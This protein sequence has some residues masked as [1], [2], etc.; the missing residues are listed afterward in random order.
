M[1]LVTLRVMS[2]SGRITQP[3]HVMTIVR[4]VA[5]AEAVSAVGRVRM[6]SDRKADMEV[7]LTC[8][9]PDLLC[10]KGC[11]LPCFSG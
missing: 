10:E 8:W 1:G 4:N 3:G 7:L 11:A 2:R 6:F 5:G 9:S